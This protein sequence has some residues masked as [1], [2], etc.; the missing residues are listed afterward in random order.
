MKQSV[1]S[2]ILLRGACDVTSMKVLLGM[3]GSDDSLRA[4]EQTVERARHAGDEV[5]IAIVENPQSNRKPD[6]VEER[7]NSVLEQEE[8]DATVC[9]I[10]GHAG[11]ELVDFAE[12]EGFDVIALGGGQQSPMGKI[13]VGHIA[14][15]V[16]LNAQTTVKLVR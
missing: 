10:S 4:L 7:I 1:R 14:E 8:F 9:R 11:S 6:E 5:T 2:A 16:L 12:R 13:Q 3:G 15:F